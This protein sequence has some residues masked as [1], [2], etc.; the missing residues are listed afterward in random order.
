MLALS[1][2]VR[3]PVREPVVV[4]LKVMLIE[5]VEPAATDG[6]QVFVCE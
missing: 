4:G 6:P 1:V 3:V 5:Q 2:T